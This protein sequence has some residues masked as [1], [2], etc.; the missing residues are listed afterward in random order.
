M[1]TGKAA[2]RVGGAAARFDVMQFAY[3][4]AFEA[5]AHQREIF[6][7][8][9]EMQKFYAAISG[10]LMACAVFFAA[11]RRRRAGRL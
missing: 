8:Q 6:E 7:K 9:L 5:T 1:L 10:T 2:M 4:R 3:A 11:F